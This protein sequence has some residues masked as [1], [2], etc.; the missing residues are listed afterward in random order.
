MTESRTAHTALIFGA[1]GGVGSS[2]ARRLAAS[3]W[4]VSLSARGRERLV[5]LG[6]E[7]TAHTE[8]ADA[9]DAEAV[10]NVFS[11]SCNKLGRASR[12]L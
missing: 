4:Q 5:A 2:L 8:A 10:E 9:T 6:E 1:T 7:L 12:A 11:A 3:G